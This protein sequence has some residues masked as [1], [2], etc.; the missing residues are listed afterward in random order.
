M[1][2]RRRF[3]AGPVK[4]GS[5]WG[6]SHGQA[7]VKKLSLLL[8][9]FTAVRA[10]LSL[11]RTA[12]VS[13]TPRLLTP[14]FIA[15]AIL[16]A[17]NGV[18]GTAIA[19][20]GAQ[21][22]FSPTLI[23]A[24]GTAYFG[25][26]LVACMFIT[27]MLRAVGHIRAFAALAALAA[28]GTLMLVLIVD[29]VAWVI[30]RFVMGFCFAGLFT[31]IESWINSGTA[32]ETRG[33]VLS[34]YRIIDL[35][36]VTGA[37]FLLPAFGAGGFTIFAVM[38]VMITLSL[39]PVSLADRSN[40]AP[41]E[42]F[43]FN[44]AGIWALSPLAC[45]GCIAI[46]ATNSAFRLI[47]PLY[48]ESIGLPITSVAT[49]MSAGIVGGAVLQYPLG[50]LS[51][52]FDRRTV[53]S[54]T[55][56]GAVVAGLF[57]AIIAGT[58]PLLNYIGIFF[59]GAFALPL[60]SLSAAHAND[61]ARQGQYVTVAAGLM[62]FFSL[63]AMVGP[64]VSAAIVEQFGPAALFTYTSVVHALLIG[65]AFIR[66]RMRAPVPASARGPFTM[67]LRT[68]P[69]IFRLARSEENPS[70][71]EQT[72]P[73]SATHDITDHDKTNHHRNDR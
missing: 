26:F 49:F 4:E 38:T 8:A 69:A 31:T 21:E 13:M 55:S 54:A 6:K 22:G 27:R 33:R 16:L 19:V 58:D 41:P 65:A 5:A 66:I 44:L 17:G 48:A 24:M 50:A 7:Y 42:S 3:P 40:P 12:I 15:A 23:G 37:Q 32:N 63:G 71:N 47:G 62:F 36:A 25:G 70:T 1:R 14:L 59:F 9:H 61:H 43:H 34:V 28:S 29:P 10:Y 56:F 45:I 68:S 51:D 20:R 46:G 11:Y 30:L 52:T 57:L 35:V 73:K 39:V 18:Q 60:Y 2:T 67:L 64:F 72:P 53:L